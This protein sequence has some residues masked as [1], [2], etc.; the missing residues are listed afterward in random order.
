MS[1]ES[2]TVICSNLSLASIFIVR[3]NDL[4]SLNLLSSSLLPLSFR[5]RFD[6][7]LQVLIWLQVRLGEF[8]TT[9]CCWTGYRF[10]PEH[11]EDRFFREGVAAFY[12]ECE[13]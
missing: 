7:I 2:F 1:S 5:M 8:G 12:S 6:A 4:L 13:R 10:L 3:I 9:P 11:G